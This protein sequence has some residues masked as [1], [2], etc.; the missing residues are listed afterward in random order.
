[1]GTLIDTGCH[2]AALIETVSFY[3]TIFIIFTSLS[4]RNSLKVLNV[5][6]GNRMSV[7]DDY[8]DV[9]CLYLVFKQNT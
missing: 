9:F 5:C 1:M 7:L 3:S 4:N 2:L 6:D 8:L